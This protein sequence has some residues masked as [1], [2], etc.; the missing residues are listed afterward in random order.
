MAT[1]IK[2][3][4]NFVVL[5]KIYLNFLKMV[6]DYIVHRRRQSDFSV[7]GTGRKVLPVELGKHWAPQLTAFSRLPISVSTEQIVKDGFFL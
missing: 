5:F 3:E 6:T 4:K 2:F 1:Y 7:Y